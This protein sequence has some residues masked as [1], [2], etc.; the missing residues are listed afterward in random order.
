MVRYIQLIT[1]DGDSTYDMPSKHTEILRLDKTIRE[2]YVRK[3]YFNR[4]EMAV[5]Y[6]TGNLVVFT[7][8][9]CDLEKYLE[10][11]YQEL[12]TISMVNKT[13]KQINNELCE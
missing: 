6:D 13:Q 4:V 11:M 5:V 7:V 10:R 9:E 3:T 8:D 2:I 12:L 1:H